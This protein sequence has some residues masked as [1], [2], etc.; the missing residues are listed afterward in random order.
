MSCPLHAKSATEQKKEKEKKDD[1][2]KQEKLAQKTVQQSLIPFNFFADLV[3]TS[4]E[5][6]F[7][8]VLAAIG[9]LSLVFQVISF[10]TFTNFLFFFSIV[11]FGIKKIFGENLKKVKIPPE[12]ADKSIRGILASNNK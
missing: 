11:M 4:P 7:A 8:L 1:L 9:I 10:G 2:I 3:E 5:I 12:N 6:F